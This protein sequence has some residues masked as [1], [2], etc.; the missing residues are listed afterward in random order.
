M[1]PRGQL[2]GAS[3]LSTLAF[4]DEKFGKDGRARVLARLASEDR[5]LL[6][7][8]LLPIGWYPL[9]PFPRLLRAM[10]DELGAGDLQLATDRGIWAAIHD[11]K[12][13]HKVL[14]KLASPAWVIDRGTSLWKN[15]HDTGHWET[16]R[17][18]SRGAVATLRELGVVDEA[19][20]ATL[21]GWILGL[22]TISGC[23]EPQ[24]IHSECR[25]RG[26]QACVYQTS[27]T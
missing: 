9:P 23:R 22:L 27:W 1:T 13:I 3:Y 21:R 17:V 14:L 20:C 16:E 26:D 15:F 2:K 6:D 18:G 10:V 8:L 12:T 5:A 4:I 24:A 7:S 25:A 19:M 11:M